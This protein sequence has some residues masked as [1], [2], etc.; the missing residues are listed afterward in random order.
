MVALLFPG[1]GSQCAA[2]LT[3]WLDGPQAQESVRTWSE[4]ADLD[5][6]SAGTTWSS[7]Q[8]RDTAVA[9]PLLTAVALLSARELLGDAHPTA[10]CGH[11]IGE[12]PA[13][14]VAGVISPEEAITLAALRGRAMAAAARLASTSMSA[15]LGG[16]PDE[17]RQRADALGLEV[18]TVNVA[19]QVVLGGP[20]DALAALAQAPPVGA[21]VRPLEVAGAFH[22]AAMAPARAALDQALAAISPG[23]PTLTVIA[24]RDG[25]VVTD[26]RDA[27]NRLSGQLTAPVRFDLCLQT[28]AAS[29]MSGAVE[30]APGGTLI[31]LARR[32][33]PGVEVVA[34]RSPHD[35]VDARALLPQPGEHPPV[36]WRAVPS[37]DSGMVDQL[38][39]AGASVDVGTPV[40]VISGRGGAT[41]VTAPISGTVTEWLV[42][43]GDPVRAGQLLAVLA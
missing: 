35:L 4:L 6:L 28:L 27:L 36:A 23:M 10:V 12:L 33:L 38:L 29:G 43:P 1:Q 9:Q 15:V 40:A 22:T 39:A 19:G 42:M 26:G 7:E 30:V 17:V 14:A 3:P 13:L 41:M 37:P 18:A 24:N 34:L 11:S 5:L 32:A 20:V 31:A 25:A 8:I 2:M 21:R 16:D